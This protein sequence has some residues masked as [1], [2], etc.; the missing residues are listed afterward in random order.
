[1]RLLLMIC[2]LNA[3]TWAATI[4]IPAD[5]PKIQDGITVS[6]PGDTILV[7]PGTYNE[8]INFFGR[9]ITVKS[10][11]GADKTIIKGNQT[12]SVVTFIKGEKKKAVLDGFTITNGLG[13]EYEFYDYNKGGGIVCM[14]GSSPT[15]INNVIT[16]NTA[17]FGC[18]IH[19]GENSSPLIMNNTISHNYHQ[20][21]MISLGGGISCEDQS[22]PTIKQ[23]NISDNYGIGIYVSQSSPLIEG[24][25][26]I[27][28]SPE[29]IS[30]YFSSSIIKNNTISKNIG[31]YSGGIDSLDSSLFI[32]GNTITENTASD[33]TSSTGAGITL[34]SVISGTTV[35]T[36]NIISRNISGSRGGGIFCAFSHTKANITNN[37]IS[38][39][40]A[41][42]GGGGIYC[43]QNASL[44]VTNTILW[45]NSAPVGP[46]IELGY[47]FV[48]KSAILTISYSNVRG[49]MAS[50]KVDPICILH[51]GP[52]MINADPLFVDEKN[53]DFHL[54][55]LSPCKDSGSNMAHDLPNEDFEGDPRIAYG[56]ADMGVDE[57]HTHL[58][59]TGNAAPGGNIQLNL[60]DTPNSNP[61][62][63]WLGSGVLNPP[64][65]VPG[66]G[67]WYLQNPILMTIPLGSIPG[68][69]GVLSLPIFIPSNIIAPLNL[70][71][72][73]GIGL[74]LTNLCEL[75]I[76]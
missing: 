12:V 69:N 24:N 34:R 8:H 76:K 20:P 5:Y 63:L 37:I 21:G 62:V 72:Q 46:E 51:W 57:F 45:N 6:K 19:C 55:F 13:R 4:N 54:T 53:D 43:E 18:G 71:L 32:T 59:Y 7:A 42:K 74:K 1:M 25:N 67:D 38:D 52:G 47:L 64:I 61:V 70:P 17:D 41:G 22:S 15:I 33:S 14:Y 50:V 27:G 44:V 28:N 48:P 2:L 23:N 10:L 11:K 58:Y 40:I 9:A 39:N 60:I 68:P 75:L 31:T 65:P 3:T 49:G 35:I 36:N 73:A 66:I 30:C 29:G 56:T 26:I 16:N